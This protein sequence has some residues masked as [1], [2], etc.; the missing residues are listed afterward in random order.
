[1]GNVG[2]PFPIS[3]IKYPHHMG[4][5]QSI[6]YKSTSIKGILYNSVRIPNKL[7]RDKEFRKQ[8]NLKNHNMAYCANTNQRRISSK[9][10]K[11][12]NQ[13]NNNNLQHISYQKQKPMKHRLSNRDKLRQRLNRGCQICG[14]PSFPNA[15]SMNQHKDDPIHKRNKQMARDKAMLQRIKDAKVNAQYQTNIGMNSDRV[16]NEH[17]YN[18]NQQRKNISS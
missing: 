14:I 16:Y 17:Y 18:N 10:I 5:H 12:Q 6:S 4:K 1:M 3:S 7:W 2:I 15:H 9:M 13:N 11:Q 8:Y